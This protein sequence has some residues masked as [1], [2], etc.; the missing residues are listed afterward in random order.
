MNHISKISK[1]LGLDN[2]EII[3]IGKYKAKIP[4]ESIKEKPGNGKLMKYQR[5]HVRKSQK[6]G[7]QK[8]NKGSTFRN[9]RE[10]QK[11]MTS[12]EDY[13]RVPRSQF[14]ENVII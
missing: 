10:Y 13:N 11:N 8:N 2:Q 7:N 4:F 9:L 6:I 14:S 1:K 12:E 3:Y 5:F